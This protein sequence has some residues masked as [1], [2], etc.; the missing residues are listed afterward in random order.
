M[1]RLPDGRKLIAGQ[2]QS[3]RWQTESQAESQAWVRTGASEAVG[4][5]DLVSSIKVD[6]H[7]KEDS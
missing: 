7:G 2:A 1:Y 6:E 3:R 5:Q 4:L